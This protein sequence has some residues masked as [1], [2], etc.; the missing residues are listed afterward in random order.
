L[1]KA[2]NCFDESGSTT[3]LDNVANF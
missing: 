2:L 3:G 1:K